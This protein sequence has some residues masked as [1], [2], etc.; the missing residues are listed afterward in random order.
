M[1][2]ELLDQTEILKIQALSLGP[3]GL[4]DPPFRFAQVLLHD[5]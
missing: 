3:P 4:L 1:V 5:A 2:P